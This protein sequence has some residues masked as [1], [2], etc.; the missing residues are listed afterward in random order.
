MSMQKG[1]TMK[2]S[3]EQM[4]E[5]R[6]I[7]LQ[8][9]FRLFA[10]RNIDSV[11]ME[12]VAAETDYGIR[13]FYRYFKD[14][15]NLVIETATWAFDSFMAQYRTR[16]RRPIEETTA[17]EDYEFFLDSFLDLYRNHADILCFNQFFNVY[18]RSEKID[19]G[20]LQPYGGMIDALRER[21][22]AVYEKGRQDWTLRTD[23]PE[24]VIFSATLHLM[25][26]VVTR[27]A[28]GLVYD[29]GVDPEDE[30]LAMKEML[31]ARYTTT[32]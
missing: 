14:K 6:Q 31:L 32:A 11:S 17:A 5:R 23:Y 28:V 4:A 12:D 27:Y 18:V 15:D 19:A 22:R 1:D 16:R 20:Q 29:A 2:L 30:L 9:A 25:L 13:S 24:E 26:A 7:M 3:A 10:E 8:T 21:F